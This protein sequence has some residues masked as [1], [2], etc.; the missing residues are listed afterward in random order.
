MIILL[1]VNE[2]TTTV[3]VPKDE[4]SGTTESTTKE[5]KGHQLRWL[6][7][8]LLPV[9]ATFVF[10]TCSYKQ[11]QMKKK[12]KKST[13]GHSSESENE[14]RQREVKVARPRNRAPREMIARNREG[15]RVETY[16]MLQEKN[17]TAM[18]SKSNNE[19]MELQG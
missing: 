9:L 10:F 6:I 1:E 11:R 5:N 17:E 15:Q 16:D 18:Q 19:L 4:D 7:F 8:L 3:I 14:N 12:E 13:D 2:S